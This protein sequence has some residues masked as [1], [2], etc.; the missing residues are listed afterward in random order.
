MPGGRDVDAHAADRVDR[1]RGFLI[2]R[3]MFAAATGAGSRLRVMVGVAGVMMA[4]M[5]GI[6]AAG[7]FSCRHLL[8][9]V[10]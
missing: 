4:A 10:S 2:A 8:H 3:F 6:P 1:Y 5:G 9:S 7:L